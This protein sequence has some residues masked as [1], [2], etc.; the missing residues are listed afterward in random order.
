M[1]QGHGV[2]GLGI[3]GPGRPGKQGGGA[4][5]VA[6]D[7]APGHAEAEQGGRGGVSRG[8]GLAAEPG[9]PSRIAPVPGAGGEKPAQRGG[10]R[11]VGLAGGV[12]EGQG[13]G[14][15]AED[16][17]ALVEHVGQLE[18]GRN[19]AGPGRALEEPARLQRVGRDPLSGKVHEPQ[20]VGCL[21]IAGLGGS[22]AQRRGPGEIAGHSPARGVEVGQTVERLG[23]AGVAGRGEKGGSL[24][25][26]AAPGVA[27]VA[28]GEQGPAQGRGRPGVAARCRAAEQGQGLVDVGRAALSGEQHA[29]QPG[30]GLGV[31]PVRGQTVPAGSR[32][33]VPGRRTRQ[34][35]GPQHAR[36][37]VSGGGEAE[38]VQG[39][40]EV[41]GR[42]LAGLEGKAQTVGRGHRAPGRGRFQ[43]G[44]GLGDPSPVEKSG[45]EFRGLAG[46][47][48]EPEG[49][50]QRQEIAGDGRDAAPSGGCG[51][52]SRH[53]GSSAAETDRPGGFLR[54]RP[55]SDNPRPW[56]PRPQN[57][58]KFRTT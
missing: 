42:R 27:G 36:N 48:D 19:V 44:K 51:V 57:P 21:G 37:V 6:G 1:E 52:W 30:H 53:E 8:R 40:G 12:V 58:E 33:V 29:P 23:V 46:G 50:G 56:P 32:R 38:K 49:A 45:A 35:A 39:P 26:P 7:V 15:V 5:H 10:R 17:E 25:G 43:Q 24:L 55:P 11:V 3:S 28:Q 22:A 9:R 18:H 31:A 16:A 54:Q 2:H 47:D 34:V 20:V 4:G 41:A 14:R 13:P